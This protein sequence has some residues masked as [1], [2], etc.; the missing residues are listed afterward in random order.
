MIT[1]AI[2]KMVVYISIIL[3]L[4]IIMYSLCWG[5][6]VSIIISPH[7]IMDYVKYHRTPAW[8][9]VT[10]MPYR[11]SNDLMLFHYSQAEKVNK[12][13]GIQFFHYVSL[14]CGDYEFPK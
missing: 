6:I 1:P 4:S 7:T 12:D 8:V 14:G 13:S 10:T 3:G 2:S 5:Y 11:L 9:V